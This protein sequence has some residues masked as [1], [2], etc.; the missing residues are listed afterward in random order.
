MTPP[1][2]EKGKICPSCGSGSDMDARFCPKCG[3][4]L[5]P[6]AVDAMVQSELKIPSVGLAIEFPESTAA[7]FPKA[8]EIAR[9]SSGFQTCKKNKKNWYLAVYPSNALMEAIPL[10]AALSGIRNRRLYLD[11]K[12]TPWNEVFGFVW[13]AE[14]RAA[15]Y[16]PVEYCFGGDENR[17]N[18]WGCKQANMEWTEWS[19]WFCYGKWEK[20][21]MLGGK[22]QWRFD[23]ERISH[24]LATNLF[25][26]R[27]C[28]HL[29]TELS[30]SVLKYIPDTIT[31]QSDPNWGFRRVSEE[32]PG[33]I[34]V[35]VKEKLGGSSY[36]TEYWSDGV[37]P[38]GLQG[39]KDV[40]IKALQSL[41]GNRT[42]VNDLLR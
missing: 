27:F 34:K 38:K 31:P 17:L 21:G 6:A 25:R 41:G 8:L 29:Q 40:L 35:T 28:P 13:C 14:R 9:T 18:P 30:D 5:D 1:I 16:R 32:M 42:S 15:A 22:I 10:S 4:S 36:E 11:G 24:D 19:R 33:S 3:K 7:L 37:C 39:F 26:F 20:S 23:K 2:N 12:E